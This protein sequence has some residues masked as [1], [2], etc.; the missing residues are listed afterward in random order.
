MLFGGNR[1]GPRMWLAATSIVVFAA[2]FSALW[3]IMANSWMQTPQG[4][5]VVNS[6]APARAV[7]TDFTQVMFTPSFLP[8]IFHVFFAS[9]TAGSALVLSVSAYYILRKRNIDLA[10]ANFTLALPFF[11]TF[12]IL[13]FIAAGPRQAI[14]VTDH[15][16]AKLA[17]IEGVFDDQSCAPL[18]IV[19]WVNESEQK[20]TGL[21]VPCLLSLL[22][23]RS[24]DATVTGLNSFPQDDWAPVNLAFQVY[25]LMFNLA[26]FFALM[27]VIGVALYFW[28]RRIFTWRWVL[29]LFVIN[30][31][32]TEVAIITGWWTAEIG[33]QPWV[34]WNVLRT[35]DAVSPTLTTTQAWFSVVMFVVLYSLLLVLF[36]YL[37]NAKIKRGPEPL[38]DVETVDVTSLPNTVREIFRSHGPRA[39]G[40]ATREPAHPVEAREVTP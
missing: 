21:S 28:K 18:Y 19:G 6:P 1:L 29:W 9:W 24:K 4:Y 3:I 25:H 33:R 17:A 38:E 23:Y 34:V 26:M 5:E 40:D 39:S 7:M 31:A 22:S 32:F 30:V 8:R 35:E 20:V 2:H 16:Q 27:A 13:N 37:L 14:E 10:K 15:Q 36:L 11:V 12:A